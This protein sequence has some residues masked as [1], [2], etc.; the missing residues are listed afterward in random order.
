MESS[1]SSHAS[2]DSSSSDDPERT[3]ALPNSL[4]QI[5]DAYATGPDSVFDGTPQK[6]FSGDSDTR[7]FA[8][9]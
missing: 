1:Y 3:S 4:L 2:D 9:P 7:G 8:L 6:I 5:N